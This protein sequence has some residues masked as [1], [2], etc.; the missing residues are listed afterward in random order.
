MRRDNGGGSPAPLARGGVP[1]VPRSRCS[2]LRLSARARQAPRAPLPTLRAPPLACSTAPAANAPPH[3]ARLCSWALRSRG[4]GLA[5]SPCGAVPAFLSL[6]RRPRSFNPACAGGQTPPRPSNFEG[7]D[8]QRLYLTFP[9]IAVIIH[10]TAMRLY[11]I[12][13]QPLSPCCKALITLAALRDMKTKKPLAEIA[14]G[15]LFWFARY[16]VI[17]QNVIHFV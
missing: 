17:K 7:G 8:G 5:G 12:N 15:F 1:R 3:K 4:R 9:H 2:A 14:S 6:T 10:K 11:L 13:P 16:R